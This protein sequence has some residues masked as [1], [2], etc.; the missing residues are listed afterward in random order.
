MSHFEIGL[1]HVSDPYV[2]EQFVPKNVQHCCA[3]L[4]PHGQTLQEE[5]QDDGKDKQAEEN[6]KDTQ[7]E[8]YV[9]VLDVFLLE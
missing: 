7:T 6:S 1:D 5:V 3:E 8:P 9:V 4:D 2:V